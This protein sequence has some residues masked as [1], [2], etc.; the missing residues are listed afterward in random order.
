ML[1]FI[2]WPGFGLAWHR[3]CSRPCSLHMSPGERDFSRL[4]LPQQGITP[5]PRERQ[6]ES[7]R[8]SEHRFIVSDSFYCSAQNERE[9]ER[10][11]QLLPSCRMHFCGFER[12][13]V[14]ARQL[15][16]AH[17]QTNTTPHTLTLPHTHTHTS[18]TRLGQQLIS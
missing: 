15:A 5:S 3:S 8:E 12:H 17:T 16:H 7:E 10:V 11:L 6:R 1:S 14:H 13:V 4:P 9:R 18:L 2:V